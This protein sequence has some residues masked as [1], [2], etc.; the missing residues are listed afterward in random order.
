MYLNGLVGP[1]IAS[2]ERVAEASKFSPSNPD[3]AP[4]LGD[5]DIG[6]VSVSHL[7]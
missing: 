6:L 2:S 5:K 3:S 7:L 1:I 4:A